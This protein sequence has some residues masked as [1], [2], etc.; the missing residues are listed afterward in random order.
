MMT[1]HYGRVKGYE[2]KSSPLRYS[3]YVD[4]LGMLERVLVMWIFIYSKA[5]MEVRIKW[6]LKV[7]IEE[8]L[9]IRV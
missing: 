8:Q 9:K 3:M 1:E 4:I 2:L 7:W 6:Q 5:R